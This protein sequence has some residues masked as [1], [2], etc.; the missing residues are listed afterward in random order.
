MG[1]NTPKTLSAP[2]H[3]PN[4]KPA[5]NCLAAD[6]SVAPAAS[7]RSETEEFLLAPGGRRG[8]ADPRALPASSSFLPGYR[9]Q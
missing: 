3:T 6:D 7:G 2:P 8:T 4:K 1:A 9:P 5:P